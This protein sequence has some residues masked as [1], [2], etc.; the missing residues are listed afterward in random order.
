[1]SDQCSTLD[2][3][4]SDNKA[5]HRDSGNLSA[6]DVFDNGFQGLQ[7]EIIRFNDP[8]A[9]SLVAM[10][11]FIKATDANVEHFAST[12]NGQTGLPSDLSSTVTT[13]KTGLLLDGVL[14]KYAATFFKKSFSASRCRSNLRNRAISS[15][16]KNSSAGIALRAVTHHRF[17]VLLLIP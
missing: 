11:P 15:I 10:A 12:A 5:Q 1:M 14:A 17:R 4:N 6:A 8:Q 16:A 2:V 13:L 9:M 7:D 3:V